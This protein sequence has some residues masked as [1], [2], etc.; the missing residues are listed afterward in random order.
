MFNTKCLSVDPTEGLVYFQKQNDP[1]I[2][3][4]N[5]DLIIGADGANSV[6]RQSVLSDRNGGITYDSKPYPTIW[7]SIQLKLVSESK[8]GSAV[9]ISDK[10]M[11]CLSTALPNG[12][13]CLTMWWTPTKKEEM[14][15][16]TSLN[17]PEA[18]KNLM[19]R[20]FNDIPIAD[21]I[22]VKSKEFFDKKSA[23]MSYLRANKFYHSGGKVVIMGDAAHKMNAYLGEGMGSSL[24]DANCLFKHLQAYKWTNIP[25]A[26]EKYS[27]E[28]VPEAHALIDLNFLA[29]ASP[30]FRIVELLWSKIFRQPML[31]Q[32]LIGGMFTYQQLAKK[33]KFWINGAKKAYLKRLSKFEKF[34]F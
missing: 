5:F 22:E 26:L 18:V 28:S 15:N 29:Y 14:K 17:T 32:Q 8:I 30:L 10:N 20:I 25:S 11:I 1:N 4:S 24:R 21:N 2:F 3:K 33:N 23:T 9:F 16:P 7:K 19:E 13:T 6:V 34:A 12:N 27:E 31:F